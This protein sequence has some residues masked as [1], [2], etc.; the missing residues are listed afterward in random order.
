ML[1]QVADGVWG[2]AKARGVWS[3]A[4][5]WCAGGVGLIPLVRSRHRR[6]P[7]STS[8][9]MTWNRPRGIPVVAGFSTH[10][11]G[12]TC[13]G[14]SRFG[15]HAA[16]RH[17]RRRPGLPAKAPGAGRQSMAAQSASGHPSRA[18][19]GSSPRLPAERG[20][21]CPGRDHRA[22]GARLGHARG[23][24]RGPLASCSPANMLSDRPDP[25]PRPFA[26]PVRW[27]PYETAL[28]RL[29]EGCP[30]RRCPG[31]RPRGRCSEG[32]RSSGPALP[33]IMAYIDALRRGEET[34]R[35]AS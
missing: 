4:I 27:P 33:P 9:P 13:S 10:P 5:R 23:P 34:G 31:P 11:T 14:I 3:N 30:P 35:R 24:P 8:S 28:D 15:G 12:T 17:P 2:P 1:N 26:A 21:P 25:A 18:G 7:I 19:R 32:S 29:G 6:F 20:T 22:S 16:L